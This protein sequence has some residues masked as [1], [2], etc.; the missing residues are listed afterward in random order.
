MKNARRFIDILPPRI[1]EIMYV[2]FRVSVYEL[3]HKL[4]CTT[5]GFGNLCISI[6]F[7]FKKHS[8]IYT[9]LFSE[10]RYLYCWK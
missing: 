7:I 9:A 3:P 4:K 10:D 5:C 1:K 2:Y 8:L 6:E